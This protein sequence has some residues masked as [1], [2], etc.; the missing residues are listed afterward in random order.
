MLNLLSFRTIRSTR[1]LG[2]GVDA[3]LFVTRVN[4]SRRSIKAENLNGANE[5]RNGERR[6]SVLLRLADALGVE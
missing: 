6:V 4:K 1:V 5:K 2:V 3:E